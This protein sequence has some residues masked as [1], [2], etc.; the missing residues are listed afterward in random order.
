MPQAANPMASIHLYTPQPGDPHSV[1]HPYVLYDS[2]L[3]SGFDLALNPQ[4]DYS[5]SFGNNVAPSANNHH[6]DARVCLSAF[7]DVVSNPIWVHAVSVPPMVQRMFT[8]VT[9]TFTVGQILGAT[10]IWVG[11]WWDDGTYPDSRDGVI[12]Y[13]RDH[14]EGDGHHTVPIRIT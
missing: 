13:F 4:G 11:S 14:P 6:A 5:L 1:A 2:P 12:A 3:A 9:V 7:S 8:S 10:Q